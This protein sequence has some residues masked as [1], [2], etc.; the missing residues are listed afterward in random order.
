MHPKY[1]CCLATYNDSFSTQLY[2][3]EMDCTG[4]NWEDYGDL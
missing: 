2:C 1:I 4:R 3:I